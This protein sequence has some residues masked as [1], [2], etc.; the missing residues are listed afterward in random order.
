MSAG[1][2]H[3]E[4]PG[5]VGLDGASGDPRLD[6]TLETLQALQAE[7]TIVRLMHGKADTSNVQPLPRANGGGQGLPQLH[8]YP[9]AVEEQHSVFRR[10]LDP[11]KVRMQAAGTVIIGI[12]QMDG[13]P[14][15]MPP[16]MSSHVRSIADR[17]E[18]TSAQ[19]LTRWSV[20]SGVVSIPCTFNKQHLLDNSPSMIGSFSLTYTDMKLLDSIALMGTR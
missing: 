8:R 7:G 16:L 12:V 20:Q 19:I 18:K 2:H 15:S 5:D 13:F 14:D 3:T 9:A 17:L 4:L 6:A 1:I 11:T 10:K